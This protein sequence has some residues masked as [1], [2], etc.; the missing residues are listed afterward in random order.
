[1]SSLTWRFA[2]D[3]DAARLIDVR[4]R[5]LVALLHE[6]AEHRQRAGDRQAGAD[7]DVTATATT[8]GAAVAAA[9]AAARRQGKR[10][11][12]RRDGGPA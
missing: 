4:H 7:H 2:V 6:R 10:G 8:T 11:Y 9:A 12:D 3:L 5:P 1:M